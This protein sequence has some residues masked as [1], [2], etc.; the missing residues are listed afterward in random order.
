MVRRKCFRFLLRSRFVLFYFCFFGCFDSSHWWFL[1]SHALVCRR[2]SS[3]LSY[4]CR[5][6]GR[7]AFVPYR[8]SKV[9]ITISSSSFLR[10]ILSQFQTKPLS[11]W[12]PHRQMVRNIHFIRIT[13]LHFI[14]THWRGYALRSSKSFEMKTEIIIIIKWRSWDERRMKWNEKKKY[15][16]NERRNKTLRWINIAFIC[17]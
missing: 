9:R 17:K 6:I 13:I 5:K 16:K 11:V 15:K 7:S 2:R 1:S 12:R 10:S 3:A 4:R 14:R 8:S